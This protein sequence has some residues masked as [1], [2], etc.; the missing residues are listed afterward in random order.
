VYPRTFRNRVVWGAECGCL[1]RF[2]QAYLKGKQPN[3]QQGCAVAWLDETTGCV[4]FDLV[5]IE[6]GRAYWQ[7]RAYKA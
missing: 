2:D 1:C 6:R 7:G 3:W 5:P 4:A